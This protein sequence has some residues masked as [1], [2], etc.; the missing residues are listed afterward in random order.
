MM[1]K[2]E[3]ILSPEEIK[4]SVEQER[5][6]LKENG[7]VSA[8]SGGPMEDLDGVPILATPHQGIPPAHS[9]KKKARVSN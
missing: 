5:K 3:K 6:W 1:D 7:A 4:K 2:K 8:V 9:D